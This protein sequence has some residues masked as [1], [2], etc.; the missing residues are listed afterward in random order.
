M[1]FKL[2]GALIKFKSHVHG[3]GFGGGFGGGHGAWM[4][5]FDPQKNVHIHVHNTGAEAGHVDYEKTVSEY[6]LPVHYPQTH[7]SYRSLPS[8]QA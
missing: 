2:L 6:A 1:L 5:K 4:D 8:L 7:Q 3:G